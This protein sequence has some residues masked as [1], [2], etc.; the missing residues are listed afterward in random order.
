MKTLAALQVAKNIA[1]VA[2]EKFAIMVVVFPNY[3]WAVLA[4]VI[5]CV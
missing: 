1:I 2:T 3:L 4:K 5:L